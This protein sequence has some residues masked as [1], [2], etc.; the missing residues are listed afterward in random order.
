M[1]SNHNDH[2]S[3]GPA[4]PAANPDNGPGVGRTRQLLRSLHGDRGRHH[5]RL[6]DEICRVNPGKDHDPSELVECS[7]K[8]SPRG[9]SAQ[10]HGGSIC[11]SPAERGRFAESAGRAAPTDA[12]RQILL[13]A[14]PDSPA[15]RD[16]GPG[17]APEPPAPANPRLDALRNW[18]AR[19][20]RFFSAVAYDY[21]AKLYK[22]YQFKHHPVRFFED[23]DLL[24][25]RDNLPGLSYIRSLEVPFDDPQ[26]WWEALYFK[27][28]FVDLSAQLAEGGSLAPRRKLTEILAPDFRPH[29][30]LSPRLL[31]ALPRRAALVA[32]L[33]ALLADVQVVN[34]PVIKLVPPPLA[35]ADVTPEQQQAAWAALDYGV[36]V[37]LLDP[38][39]IRF[40]E[41]QQATLLKIADALG[42]QAQA[43]S[44]LEQ[45]APFEPFLSY[46]GIGPD[47]VTLYYRSTALQRRQP[48]PHLR[49]GR[50][51]GPTR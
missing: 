15:G 2:D 31:A 43:K 29:A 8:L 47:S 26:E 46:L 21:D 32:E 35:G 9:V 4:S 27:L 49:R 11:W 7:I 1:P 14:T 6:Y 23:L 10:R 12:L 5:D 13:P 33:S 30:L 17:A 50:G 42:C 20:S 44:W 19:S 18:A 48:A 28:R 36:N 41:E 16:A 34:D 38:A 25:Q 37:N 40:V 39:R 51:R 22:L 45:V 3:A 24:G